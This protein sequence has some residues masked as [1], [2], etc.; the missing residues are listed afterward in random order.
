MARNIPEKMVKMKMLAEDTE[1]NGDYAKA[2]SWH[3]ERIAMA[4]VHTREEKEGWRVLWRAKKDYAQFTLCR[5]KDFLPKAKELLKDALRLKPDDAQSATLL[6]AVCAEI[7]DE[8][9]C[10]FATDLFTST[11]CGSDGIGGVLRALL[12]R[13]KGEAA[14]QRRA[15][16][17]AGESTES[18][19]EGR[20]VVAACLDGAEFFVANSLVGIAEV[21]LEWAKEEEERVKGVC[22]VLT[23]PT[24]SVGELRAKG[25][26]LKARVEFTLKQGEADMQLVTEA[27]RRNKGGPGEPAAKLVAAE[28]LAAKGDKDEALLKYIECLDLLGLD[29]PYRVYV[30]TFGLLWEEG[31]Y[32][33]SRE[34][35][36][37]AAKTKKY[38]SVW[39]NI[40]RCSLKL[41]YLDDAEDSLQES[42]GANTNDSKSW[43]LFSL[44]CLASG[45]SRLG[46]ANEALKQSLGLGVDDLEVLSEL[47]G[48]F[49]AIDQFG[50]AEAIYLRS[51]EVC[52]EGG[53]VTGESKFLRLLGWVYECKREFGNAMKCYEDAKGKGGGANELDKLRSRLG[54]E[55]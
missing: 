12:H 55:L 39:L 13:I 20:K 25:C 27:E 36:F 29:I 10:A 41:G 17:V 49:V 53:D 9:S 8:D 21:C 2:E 33:E 5:G 37:R 6:I 42:N 7:G 24:G 44:V 48:N 11:G 52:K 32:E 15:L 14:L 23:L 4:E 46:E 54:S 43:G 45:E 38:S 40:A 28:A 3:D 18:P 35:M 47:G 34:V 22:K 1:G 31:R 50:Q 30:A 16:R 51:V 19:F 26:L